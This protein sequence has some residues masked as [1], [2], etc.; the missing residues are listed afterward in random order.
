MLVPDCFWYTSASSIHGPA[1]GNVTVWL[2]LPSGPIGGGR[3]TMSARSLRTKI[4]CTP[5]WGPAPVAYWVSGCPLGCTIV[6][7]TFTD[8]P[9]GTGPDGVKPEMWLSPAALPG[10]S[11]PGDELDPQP[12][13]QPVASSDSASITPVSGR[14]R[15]A[16]GT[17]RSCGAGPAGPA[18]PRSGTGR[19]AGSAVCPGANPG[20]RRTPAVVRGCGSRAG[21]GGRAPLPRSGT[22]D[23]GCG[24]P[25]G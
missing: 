14:L 3:C 2:I 1:A 25:A 15:S 13:L 20:R 10:G 8:L 17:D 24:R 22:A 23:R 16:P 6:N 5:V 9:V 21:A 11:D 7:D 18:R 19:A 12:R 4:R